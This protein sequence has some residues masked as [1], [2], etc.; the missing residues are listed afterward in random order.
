MHVGRLTNPAKTLSTALACA[1]AIFALVAVWQP[2]G[3]R[4]AEA[5]ITGGRP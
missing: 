4:V 5:A 3:V 1:I 2:G